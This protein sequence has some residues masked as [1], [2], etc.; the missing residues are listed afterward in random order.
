MLKREVILIT[1]GSEMGYHAK[2]CGTEGEVED[3]TEEDVVALK[4][5]LWNWARMQSENGRWKDQFIL[6]Q[7][8]QPMLNVMQKGME[9]RWF[10]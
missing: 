2:W 10:Q 1:G 3:L 6:K 4:K 7:L 8:M 9:G 5:M